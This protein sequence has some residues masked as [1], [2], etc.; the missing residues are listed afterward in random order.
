MRVDARRESRCSPQNGTAARS[1]RGHGAELVRRSTD[2]GSWT[3]AS[4]RSVRSARVRVPMKCRSPRLGPSAAWTAPAPRAS[5][6]LVRSRWSWNRKRERRHTEIGAPVARIG[7]PYG[8]VL[9]PRDCDLNPVLGLVLT[10]PPAFFSG[11]F[12]KSRIPRP[13]RAIEPR[14]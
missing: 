12:G 8:I 6:D 13:R 2:S 3:R 7:I 5:L 10:A 9:T 11:S 14:R 1:C 4:V